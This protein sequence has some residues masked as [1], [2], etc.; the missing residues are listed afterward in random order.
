M[1]MHLMLCTQGRRWKGAL[2][3]HTTRSDGRRTSAELA[4]DYRAAGCDF[5]A[6]TDHWR[7]G[8]EG[9]ADGM[10]LLSGCEYNIGNCVTHPVHHIVG[11]GMRRMTQVPYDECMPPETLVDGIHAAGGL[12]ILAHPAW[13]MMDP[14][15][16]RDMPGIDA[17]EIFNT[18]S[19]LPNNSRADSSLY[20]DIWAAGGRCLP[21][22]ATDDFHGIAPQDGPASFTVLH[23]D[24]LTR[25]TI[26]SA[27]RGGQ[28]YGSQA[29][30]IHALYEQDGV[31]YAEFSPSAR[32]LFTT[33]TPGGDG[34]MFFGPLTKAAYRIR[35]EDRFVRLELTDE[36]GLRAW[37]KAYALPLA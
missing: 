8:E 22:L 4:A 24:E 19:G 25:D 6:F 10:L 34:K 32:A 28:C 36:H 29:P 7:F 18:V 30:V 23:S 21:V 37:T 17:V 35:P 5:I 13:S 16:L 9:E 14:A 1:L 3:L 26:L 11:L 15:V 33:N 20:V 27:I 31:V 2:H 12:A